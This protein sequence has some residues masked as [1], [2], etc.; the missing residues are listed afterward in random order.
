MSGGTMAPPFGWRNLLVE[1]ALQSMRR[2]M[3]RG[4]KGELDVSDVF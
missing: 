4:L 3:A 2:V 1:F